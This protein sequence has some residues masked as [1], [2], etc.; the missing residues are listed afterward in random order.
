MKSVKVRQLFLN[1]FKKKQHSIVTSA[2]IVVKG[3]PTL[4]F[5]NSGMNQFKPVFL[6]N[7]KPS[8]LRIANSQKCLRV[9]GKHNDLEEVGHDTYHHTMFEMLGNWSF[10]DY[11]KKEAI[12]WAWEF[13]TKELKLSKSNLYVTVFE[14]DPKA[15]L[16]RDRKSDELWRRWVEKD[17]IIDGNR[18]DN[19]WEMGE[20][21]PCGPCSEI[22]IDLRSEKEKREIPGKNLVNKGHPKVVEIWNLVFIQFNRKADGKLENLPQNHIDT[23][24]GLER[25]AMVLQNV[26]STYDTDIFVSL[27]N[28]IQR[29]DG[30]S[31]G[32]DETIDIAIR[33][34]V[35]HVRA[36]AF[37]IADG[38]LPSNN[39]AG[40]VI[41]RI[42]RRAIR[43][44]Y[45]FLH[46]KKPFIYELVDTLR[47]EM[48]DAYEEL[49]TQNSLIKQVIRQEEKSFLKTIQEGIRRLEKLKSHSSDKIVDGAFAFE[50]YDTYGFPVDLT[51]LIL[52]ESGF[53]LDMDGFNQEMKKQ[54]D[55]S[56]SASDKSLDDW[57]VLKESI[58]SEFVGYDQS[59]SVCSIVRYRKIKTKK[60]G[61][62][63]IVLNRTPFYAESSGQIGDIGVLKSG[64]DQVSV[65]DTKNENGIIVHYTKTLPK[66]LHANLEAIIDVSRRKNIEA[67]HSA[68]H[69]LHQALQ[70]FLGSH[71]EQKGSLVKAE[72]LRFDFSHFQKVGPE[73]LEKIEAFINRQIEE[74][75]PLQ[76]KREASKEE[77]IS[78][79]AIA[80]FGEKYGDYVRTVR[81]GESIE[82]CGGSHVPSTSSIWHFKIISESAIS[83][84][85]RRI[86]AI[87]GKAVKEYFEKVD[88]ELGSIKLLIQKKENIAEFVQKM[89]DEN[90]QLKA[91]IKAFTLEKEARIKERIANQ[92][93][94]FGTVEFIASKTNLDAKSLKNI[95][96]QLGKDHDNLF[97]LLTGMQSD[98]AFLSLYISSRLAEEKS[99][100]AG[101]IMKQLG[102]HINGGGGG[103]SFYATAGGKNINGVKKALEEARTMI[104]SLQ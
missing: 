81:F 69:L 56:R 84:G 36:V 21:G 34:I 88:Q 58:E 61:F 72:L 98:K 49:V 91:Q 22:H 31:Y 28:H 48:G 26:N 19:F 39:G 57:V 10:G 89:W 71:V 99:L 23:G 16:E 7:E 101:K 15:S 38:Q 32:K 55:R 60:G 80:L 70:Y 6:G 87:T 68:T 76:E 29:F 102:K 42:L 11:F 64:N 3:D 20:Q 47:Q 40:Y 66:D 14:G 41:R 52:K 94:T 4:M 44:G 97:L 12:E 33:V 63:Q 37:S 13:L 46:Q 45:T 79:G 9:S 85:V 73:K 78:E 59:A 86:E 92:S 103:Q 24:M 50:L 53:A 95:S 96:F 74:N 35:D 18:K 5:T 43:Y 17:H 8:D 104:E 65:F 93:K 67:N 30:V 83:S 62:Y 1:F 100:H 25:L 90:A 54:K 82:F 2:S 75:I 51:Q 27:I 77:A